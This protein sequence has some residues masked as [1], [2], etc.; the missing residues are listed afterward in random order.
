LRSRGVDRLDLIAQ[1]SFQWAVT[2][3]G[4]W[5][6]QGRTPP[7]A[8]WRVWMRGVFAILHSALYTPHLERGCSSVGRAV[9][10]QA[11]GQEFESPQLHQLSSAE[12]GVR[13]A[14]SSEFRTPHSEFRIRVGR[15][16]QLVR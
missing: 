7:H 9:A 3:F 11:I 4:K 5:F 13:S 1:F 16:A 10:L 14:E 15:V 6:T 2:L 8:E 12:W